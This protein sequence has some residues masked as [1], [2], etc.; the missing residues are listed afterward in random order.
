M[1]TRRDVLEAEVA[2]AYPPPAI[3]HK[4]QMQLVVGAFR[5]EST[6]SIIQSI[7]K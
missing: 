5:A 6:V 4:G 7:S 2:S 3:G 1:L